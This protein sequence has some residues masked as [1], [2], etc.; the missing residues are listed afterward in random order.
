[1]GRGHGAQQLAAHKGQQ[2]LFAL[3]Q[4]VKAFLH[5]LHRGDH[6][7]VVAHLFAVQHPPKLRGNVQ[8]RRK[9]KQRPQAGHNAFCCGLHIVGKVLAVGAGIGQQLLFIELL[10]IVKGLLGGKSKQTVGF[11]LQGGEVI[12]AGR[13]LRLF[14]P[15]HRY[16]NGLRSRTGRLGG[17][18]VVSTGKAVAG[19]LHAARRDMDNV[20]FLFLEIADLGLPVNQHFEG[21]RLHPAYGQG[22]VVEDG[23]K[24]GGVDPHQPIG[25]RPA[26]GR[27]IQAVVVGPRFQVGKAL[28]DGGVLHAGNPKALERLVAACHLVDE[29]ENQL[30]L[31][32]GVGGA[33]KAVHIG[34]L[35]QGT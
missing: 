14:L 10:G 9:G 21:G 8:P 11:P 19:R 4:P 5:K 26:Q 12:E 3:G 22:L 35:H 13:L 16:A 15:L 7:V 28:P 2:F 25:L 18:G 20:I 32:P 24:P 34:P 30:P 1:M 29:T 6:G 23:E 33:H 31:A 17:V 27:L